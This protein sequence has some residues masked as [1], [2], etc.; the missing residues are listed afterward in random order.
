M[1]KLIE[2]HP[3]API[4][5]IDLALAKRNFAEVQRALSAINYSDVWKHV[6]KLIKLGNITVDT[7]KSRG[8]GVNVRLHV[9]GPSEGSGHRTVADVNIDDNVR[10]YTVEADEQMQ[11]WVAQV[12]KNAF[13]KSLNTGLVF[14]VDD[15]TTNL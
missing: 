9:N 6:G 5:G 7:R 14:K 10:R 4:E 13:V 12:L 11:K 2:S 8:R 3:V 15:A 1:P